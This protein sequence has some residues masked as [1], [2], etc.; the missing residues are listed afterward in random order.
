MEK[1]KD[2][3]VRV[4]A[5]MVYEFFGTFGVT[6]VWNVSKFQGAMIAATIPL[7]IVLRDT[8]K[9]LIDDGKFSKAEQDQVIKTA[10]ASSKQ[11]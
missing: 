8:A 4:I 10:K 6:A 9:S 3:A 11:K 1:Y 7:V 2:F 5:L